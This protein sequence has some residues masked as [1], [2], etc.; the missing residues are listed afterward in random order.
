VATP[1][2]AIVATE[3]P[4]RFR[5]DVEGLR[6]VAVLLVVLYHASVPGVTGGYVGVDVF[7]VVSGF[8]ITTLLLRERVDTGRVSLVGFY[9]RRAR[10][11][12]P[13][14]T[15]VTLVTVIASYRFLGLLAGA[16]V[17]EDAKWTA[18]FAANIHF[19]TEQTSYLASQQPPSTLEH[20]WSLGVEEQFYLVWPLLLMLTTFRAGSRRAVLLRCGAALCVVI[21]ASFAYSLYATPL[22]GAVAFFSPLT[23]ALELGAG[24]LVATAT[25]LLAGWSPRVAPWL[26]CFGLVGV[27]ASGFVFDR[28]TA[29]PG[30]AVLLPTV[31]TA[32][33]LMAGSVRRG[34]AAEVL[35]S[36][37]PLPWLGQRS[38]SLYL[39][40]WP[41]L[42]IAFERVGMPE[43]P[44][45]PTVALVGLALALTELTYRVVEHPIR[46]SLLLRRHP[47]A[48]VT[49]GLVAI[50]TTLFSL[51]LIQSAYA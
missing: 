18:L 36:R 17:A 49:G 47:R 43:L 6:A 13:A 20:M 25:P 21:A 23:R 46:S 34:A 11:I 33:I 14:A 31:A 10:R 8:V 19:A 29:W 2:A 22:N 38:Y 24:A 44:L 9:A 41:V 1:A 3:P 28:N 45:A 27:V 40:H 30:S 4:V 26:G 39:W 48:V 35:L 42:I 15:L 5:P 51:T 12:L 50:G 16:R 32:M 37:R 7:F